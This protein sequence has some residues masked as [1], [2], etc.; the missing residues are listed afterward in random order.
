MSVAS[1]V[2]DGFGT[3]GDIAKVVTDG[4]SVTPVITAVAS[5]ITEAFGTITAFSVF[6]VTEG[7]GDATAGA[8]SVAEWIVRAR[9]R[10]R[11]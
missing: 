1:V 5:L 9:R 8:V 3:F 6:V 2:T 10:G 11:K 7:F 4:Y